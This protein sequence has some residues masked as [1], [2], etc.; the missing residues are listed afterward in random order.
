ML[1]IS[2]LLTA[3]IHF[4]VQERDTSW[5]W[6]RRYLSPLQID[7][8]VEARRGTPM[9]RLQFVLR[10]VFG[11]ES[12]PGLTFGR[13]HCGDRPGLRGSL[14]RLV[15]DLNPRSRATSPAST[16]EGHKRSSLV[17]PLFDPGNIRC[18]NDGRQPSLS[19]PHSSA[20]LAKHV[21]TPKLESA[22][23]AAKEH[24]DQVE[25]LRIRRRGTKCSQ[26]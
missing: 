1:A 17:H 10:T 8:E 11:Y 15:G 23:F 6:R 9:V 24:S 5:R 16:D 3:G 18:R 14:R 20:I 2:S 13:P 4:N 25:L 12:H 26:P 22:R 19:R 21:R 7:A